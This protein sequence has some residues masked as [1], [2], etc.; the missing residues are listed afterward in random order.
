[1]QHSYKHIMLQGCKL[2]QAIS[3]RLDLMN[4]IHIRTKLEDISY[5]KKGQSFPITFKLSATSM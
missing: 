5:N 4:V 2:I 3:F 1:M